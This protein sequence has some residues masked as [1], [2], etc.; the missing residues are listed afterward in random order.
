MRHVQFTQPRPVIA[1]F[2]LIMFSII[3]AVCGKSMPT[4]SFVHQEQGLLR[5][6]NELDARLILFAGTPAYENYL[7]G[8]P[9]KARD[10]G[11][12]LTNGRWLITAVK[13]EDYMLFRTNAAVM[14][15]SWSRAAVIESAPYTLTVTSLFSGPGQVRFHN[16]T[17]SFVEIRSASFS[18][19]NIAALAP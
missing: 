4:P 8:V 16:K 18:G 9:G 15:V 17:G 1:V 12:T 2:L 10:F 19:T 11:L 6:N 13:V 14:P 7:G 5:I 3:L